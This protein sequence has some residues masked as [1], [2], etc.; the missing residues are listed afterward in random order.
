[1]RARAMTAVVALVMLASLPAGAAAAERESGLGE[2]PARVTMG[3]PSSLDALLSRDELAPGGPAQWFMPWLVGGAGSNYVGPGGWRSQQP[4]YGPFGPYPSPQTAA[5]FG[6]TNSPFDPFTTQQLLAA[7]Q[8]NG[9]TGTNGSSQSLSV[10]Q[11]TQTGLAPFLGFN[12]A[13]LQ[14][15]GIG[16]AGFGAAGD[17]TFTIGA[18]TFTLGPGLN[19]SNATLGILLNQAVPPGFF[20]NGPGVAGFGSLVP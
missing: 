17:P 18:Q 19:V 3:T 7:N 20:V 10:A 4:F 15:L 1:M 13:T 11:L 12:L 16:S 14:A 2:G 9:G 6:A 5:F 8:W